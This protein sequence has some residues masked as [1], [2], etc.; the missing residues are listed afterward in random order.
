MRNPTD[1]CLLCKVECADQKGSHIIP[2]FLSKGIFEG[3]NPRHGLKITIHGDFTKIQDFIKED[4]ILCKSCEK[5]FN[6]LET[7][8]A[9]RLNRYDDIRFKN[10]FKNHKIENFQYSECLNFD[11]K[12]FN[13]FIY[14]I[15]WRVSISTH[16]SFEK[17]KL[18]PEDEEKIRVI[19]KTTSSKNNHELYNKIENFKC[20]PNHSHIIIRASEI[21]RPPTSHLSVASIDEDIHQLFLVDYVVLYL[22]DKTKLL[23]ILEVIDNNFDK[24]PTRIGIMEPK[25]W[26]D[27]NYGVLKNIIPDSILND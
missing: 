20:I 19:L 5:G 24:R 26:K 11:N 18:K 16:F 8:C 21:I 13:I 3:T 25:Q 1:K 9:L 27:Y 7:Y 4:H 12:I 2:K 6:L 15:I 17:F 10:E 22:T 14:S 23:P